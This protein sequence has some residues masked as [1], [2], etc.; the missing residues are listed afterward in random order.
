M[1]DNLLALFAVKFN[2]F[3]R[4]G[5]LQGCNESVLSRG[6]AT[7]SR[8]SVT[9]RYRD[10]IG[11]ISSKIID[12]L[13]LACGVRSDSVKTGYAYDKACALSKSGEKMYDWQI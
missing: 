1:S 12:L 10:H 7:A 4:L 6:I 3:S 2:C 11:S 5:R 8:L 13:L 9:L